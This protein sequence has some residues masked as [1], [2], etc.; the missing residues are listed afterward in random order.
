MD[1]I[2]PLTGLSWNN[3]QVT[4]SDS[5]IGIKITETIGGDDVSDYA[6]FSINEASEIRL[7]TI[8][9]IRRSLPLRDRTD[10]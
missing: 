7:N 10:R 1:R 4:R 5:T 3:G 6:K 9:A 2:D 8:G